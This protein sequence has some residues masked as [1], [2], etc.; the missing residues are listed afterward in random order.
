MLS[1]KYELLSRI[2][3]F[4]VVSIMFVFMHFS[5][6]SNATSTSTSSHDLPSHLFL[7]ASSVVISCEL[8]LKLQY[9]TILKTVLKNIPNL[10]FWLEQPA[11]EN[12]YLWH[13]AIKLKG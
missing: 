5:R 10:F 13:N 11:G 8:F 2:V 4:P 6:Y 12:I 7:L 9:Y 3:Q 1:C